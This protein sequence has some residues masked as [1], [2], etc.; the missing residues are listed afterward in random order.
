M[1]DVT[2]INLDK[3]EAAISEAQFEFKEAENCVI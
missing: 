1:C 2:L 3:K